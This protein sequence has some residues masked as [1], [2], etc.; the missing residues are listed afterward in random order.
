MSS[1]SLE[2]LFHPICLASVPV[3]MSLSR[4][5]ILIGF[6]NVVLLY[7]TLCLLISVVL[8]S[9]SNL[10]I[11]FLVSSLHSMTYFMLSL[12]I[13]FLP[14][15]VSSFPR[16]LSRNSYLPCCLTSSFTYMYIYVLCLELWS[17]IFTTC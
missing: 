10:T 6:I 8:P 9:N 15:S 4:Y 11:T 14:G 1:V 13:F 12:G 16:Y 5:Y 7:S 17:L 3:F 2:M